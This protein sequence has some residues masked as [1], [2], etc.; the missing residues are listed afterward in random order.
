VDDDCLPTAAV[1][2]AP[3][4]QRLVIAD[5]CRDGAWLSAAAGDAADLDAER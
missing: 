2:D 1:D 3:D 4:G 5:P